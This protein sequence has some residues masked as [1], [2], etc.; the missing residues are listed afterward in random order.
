MLKYEDI[1]DAPL[2][3][4]KAAVD[5]WSEM[6]GKLDKLATD[7]TDGMKAKA[8]KAD[9]E[10]VNAGVTKAFIGKTAKE[11]SDAVAEAR[12]VKRILEEATKPSRR[13]STT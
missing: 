4:L 8:Y 7:A 10:G 6:T 12:G 9:W 1:L 11:F 5:D 3:K 2:A 13:P